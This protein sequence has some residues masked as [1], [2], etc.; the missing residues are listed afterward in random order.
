MLEPTASERVRKWGCPL[1]SEPVAGCRRFPPRSQRRGRIHATRRPK[2]GFVGPPF[3]HPAA[4]LSGASPRLGELKF[5]CTLEAC[6]TIRMSKLQILGFA[7]A[8]PHVCGPYKF[9]HHRRCPLPSTG[10]STPARRD[11]PDLCSFPPPIGRT[12]PQNGPL[13]RHSRIYPR[14]WPQRTVA[15]VHPRLPHRRPRP[16]PRRRFRPGVISHEPS[17][18]LCRPRHIGQTTRPLRARGPRTPHPAGRLRPYLLG[19]DRR[20]GSPGSPPHALSSRHL[21]PRPH[22]CRRT[23]DADSRIRHRKGIAP[24]R[25]RKADHAGRRTRSPGATE[26]GNKP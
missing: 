23:R 19:P 15:D 22:R 16:R 25:E 8:G 10:L 4:C 1:P 2:A 18:L 14:R 3:S 7:P 17:T 13:C 24:K 5:P 21:I 20:M 26:G 12:P 11:H 9:T 6:A